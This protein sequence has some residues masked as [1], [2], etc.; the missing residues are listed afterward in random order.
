MEKSEIKDYILEYSNKYQKEQ[1]VLALK[2]AGVSDFEINEIYSEIENS[3]NSNL[4]NFSFDGTNLSQRYEGNDFNVNSNFEE[5]DYKNSPFFTFFLIFFG[6]FLPILGY[7]LIVL[8]SVFA[9]NNRKGVRNVFFSF[10]LIFGMFSLFIAIFSHSFIMTSFGINY[11]SFG[12]DDVKIQGIV[13]DG[14]YLVSDS[15]NSNFQDNL[16][17]IYFT[18]LGSRDIILKG[19]KSYVRDNRRVDCDFVNL[20]NL[21]LKRSGDEVTFLSSQ[22]GKIVFYCDGFKS[23]LFGNKIKGTFAFNIYMIN[24]ESEKFSKGKFNIKLE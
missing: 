14:L 8:G 7:I 9:F 13:F 12:N 18:Y 3:L 23:S 11:V 19:Q 20:E 15:N 4:E 2:N 16:L 24:V 6:L 1:I 10:L 17:T 21:D 5:K 22:K